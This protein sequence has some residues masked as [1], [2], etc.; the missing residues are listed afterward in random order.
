MV[1]VSALDVK[2]SVVI[3]LNEK[4]CSGL[5]INMAW[6]RRLFFELTRELGDAVHRDVE[7]CG[8][9]IQF[10][11]KFIECFFKQIGVQKILRFVSARAAA[12]GG[13]LSP[14]PCKPKRKKAEC[15]IFRHIRRAQAGQFAGWIGSH[16]RIF[17]RDKTIERGEETLRK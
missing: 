17:R 13:S 8:A 15:R 4:H 2:F 16:V 10:I 7:P 9:V 6:N 11:Q 1:A 3:D 14:R 5:F 12:A